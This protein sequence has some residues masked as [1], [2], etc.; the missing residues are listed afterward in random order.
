MYD[1]MY[2]ILLLVGQDGTETFGIGVARTKKE[3]ERL[4]AIHAC[5][6]LQVST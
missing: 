5:K 2:C 1:L 6:Q 3:S 4:A